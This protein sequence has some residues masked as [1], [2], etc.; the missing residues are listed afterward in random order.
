MASMPA[1]IEHSL[2]KPRVGLLL[3]LFGAAGIGITLMEPTLFWPGAGICYLAAAA[4]IARYVRQLKQLA[5]LRIGEM[6]ILEAIMLPVFIVMESA[7]PTYLIWKRE[8]VTI[9]TKI[10]PSAKTD[11]S[12]NRSLDYT[13]SLKCSGSRLPTKARAESQLQI[14]IVLGELYDGND[15]SKNN[16]LGDEF[17]MPG[18]RSIDLSGGFGSAAEICKMVNYGTEYISQVTIPFYIE[19]RKK[20]T[21][22]NRIFAGDLIASKLL[23]VSNLDLSPPPGQSDFFYFASASQDFAFGYR[24]AFRSASLAQKGSKM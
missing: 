8:A 17:F 20:V 24:T 10:V 13:I 19:L 7:A 2:D 15:G 14:Y 3:G 22:G 23:P 6:H 11:V 1:E 9:Q 21:S 4:T 18:D 5:L 12:K 16:F